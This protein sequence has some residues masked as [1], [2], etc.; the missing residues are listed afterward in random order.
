VAEAV[1]GAAEAA[2]VEEAV[3]E[4]E[5]A[6]EEAVAV[7]EEAERGEMQ[8]WWRSP[9]RWWNSCRQKPRQLALRSLTGCGA[10]CVVGAVSTRVVAVTEACQDYNGF[11]NSVY[12]QNGLSSLCSN[13]EKTPS[14]PPP[15][16]PIFHMHP[17]ACTCRYAACVFT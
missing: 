17:Y 11:C 15:P 13:A 1:E 16:T 14:V 12:P 5:E 8:L 2:E 3:E 10:L 9:G 6:V 7:E 4:V